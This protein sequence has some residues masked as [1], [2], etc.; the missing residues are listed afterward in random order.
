MVFV[1]HALRV[2]GLKLNVQKCNNRRDKVARSARA[3]I[4]TFRKYTKYRFIGV[5][6]SARAWIETENQS[7]NPKEL[8]SHA[9]RVRGLKLYK[10]WLDLERYTVARSARAWIETQRQ[11]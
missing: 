4:E 10:D 6:R 7:K 3:W 11:L 2:R 5:A 8:R 1:S 9:L